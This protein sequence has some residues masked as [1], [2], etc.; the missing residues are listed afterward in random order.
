MKMTGIYRFALLPDADERLFVDHMTKNVFNVLQLTRI[1]SGFTHALLAMKSDL[2]QYVWI[3][4]VNLV[5]D[6]GYDFDQNIERIQKSIAQFGV[7]IG[8]E[9]YRNISTE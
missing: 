7:L 9:T 3:V 5:T 8:T 2:R 1:T 6:H 4:T